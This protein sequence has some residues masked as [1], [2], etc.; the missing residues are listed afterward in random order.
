MGNLI[1]SMQ[2]DVLV[3]WLVQGFSKLWLD[4][5]S[6]IVVSRVGV[7]H[8]APLLRRR[9]SCLWRHQILYR[10]PRGVFT[11]PP[12]PVRVPPLARC[13]RVV[14]GSSDVLSK[15][16]PSTS[17]GEIVIFQWSLVCAPP[18]A[19][20]SHSVGLTLIWR[21]TTEQH[22]YEGW[23]GGSMTTVC[24]VVPPNDYGVFSGGSSGMPPPPL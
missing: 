7:L 10:G 22:S 5:H 23:H 13:W 9:S 16:A 11:L 8:L 1:C 2:P 6:L 4:S 19:F 18:A 24:L 3:P 15:V 17:K 20:S 14:N 21:V 12:S